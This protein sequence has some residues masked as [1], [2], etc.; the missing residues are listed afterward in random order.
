M[1]YAVSILLALSLLAVTIPS[2]SPSMAQAPA[3]SAQAPAAAEDLFTPGHGPK[4]KL[5]ASARVGSTPERKAAWDKATPEQREK[6][7]KIFQDILASAKQKAEKKMAQ[8]NRAAEDEEAT[9]VSV[10]FSDKSGRQKLLPAVQSSK[11][12]EPFQLITRGVASL[13]PKERRGGRGGVRFGHAALTARDGLALSGAQA[14]CFKGIEQFVR[15]FYQGALAR[16]PYADEFAYWTGALS[17]AQAQ[18]GSQLLAQAQNLG[19]TLFQSQEY[20]NRYRSDSEYV[21][22]LYKA[23]L[24]R[25][26]D[27]GGWDF[28]TGGVG[29]DGRAAVLQ[30]FVVCQEFYDDVTALCPAAAYDA[31]ADGLPDDLENRVADNF[32]PYYHVSSGEPD[33]FATLQDFVPLTVKQRFNPYQPPTPISHFRVS[34]YGVGYING[35][36]LSILRIDYLTLWDQD[37]GLVSGGACYAAPLGLSW[38]LQGFEGHPLDWERSAVLVAA[39]AVNNDYNFDP[40]AYGLYW[41]YTVSHEFTF[42]EQVYYL[43]FTGGPAPAGF[44]VGL[45]LSQSKHGTY[46]FNPDYL[47][48]TPGVVMDEVYRDIDLYCNC[49]FDSDPYCY[50]DLNRQINCALLY[51]YADSTFFGC[52]V[53]HFGETGGRLSGLRLNVG[54]LNAP[55]NGSHWILSQEITRQF[56]TPFFRF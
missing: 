42:T 49:F 53:E 6:A 39:P 31:D 16:Q 15:D 40:N 18:G 46:P 10:A 50:D 28:W 41:V 3:Q 48:L 47:P 12:R 11:A 45:A 30:A 19:R 1:R 24:Q 17:Q 34:K 23:F 44:H 43:D 54:E 2:T 36:L 55:L 14:G 35:Q 52:L 29:R 33:N 51:Y 7:L 9:P 20:V 27:Q 32:T 8:S 13:A 38:L 4:K 21:Y 25:E 56:N 26:P 37:S 22:D 5:P